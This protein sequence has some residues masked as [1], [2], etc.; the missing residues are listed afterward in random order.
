MN[1]WVRRMENEPGLR[2]L[3]KHIKTELSHSRESTWH[4]PKTLQ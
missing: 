3:K 2:V 4:P 1:R